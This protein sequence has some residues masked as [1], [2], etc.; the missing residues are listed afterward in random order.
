MAF[1]GT[2]F[3]DT[4]YTQPR[5]AGP[6]GRAP[7]REELDAQLTG[8]QQQLARLRQAQE[9]LERARAA[10]EEMRRQRAEFTAGRAEMLQSLTR[11]I[12]ILQKAELEAR[13]DAEQMS[14]SL[15]GLQQALVEVEHLNEQAWS[16]EGW[17]QEL[18]RA[19]TGIENARMEYNTARLKWPILD[20]KTSGAATNSPTPTSEPSLAALPLGRLFKLGLALNWPVALM[21]LLSLVAFLFVMF[22]R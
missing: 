9:Q 20:G 21:V 18:N 19:L 10:V 12:G 13:R 16:A 6:S 5:A 2:D 4:D 22:K 17:E 3:V 15:S 11:S 8:T 14:K 1:D 7:T